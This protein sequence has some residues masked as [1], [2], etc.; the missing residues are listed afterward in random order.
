MDDDRPDISLASERTTPLLPYY[1]R[2]VFRKD[3]KISPEFLLAMRVGAAQE[4]LLVELMRVDLDPRRINPVGI[5]STDTIDIEPYLR[6]I[7]DHMGVDLE[8]DDFVSEFRASA[9][10]FVFKAREVNLSV[11]K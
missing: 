5:V 9:R 1:A 10:R 6:R 8:R 3:P 11:V 7:A 4:R 2:N